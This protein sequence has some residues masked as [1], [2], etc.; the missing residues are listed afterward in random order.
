MRYDEAFQSYVEELFKATTLDR[1]QIMRLALYSAPYSKLFLAQL[2][3]HKRVDVA[4]PFP[5]WNVFDHH[6]WRGKPV[7]D[8]GRGGDV[9]AAEKVIDI[10]KSGQSRKVHDGQ[11]IRIKNAGEIKLTL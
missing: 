10:S 7:A 9:N 4:L 11:P 2:N 3:A 6:Y 8:D 5:T 1:N